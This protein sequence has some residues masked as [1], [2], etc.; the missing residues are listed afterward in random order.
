MKNRGQGPGAGGQGKERPFGPV[1]FFSARGDKPERIASEA[2]L[3]PPAPRASGNALVEFAL[4]YAGVILPLTFMLVFV[5]EMA[6]IWHSVVDFTRDGARYAATHCYEPDGSNVLAYMQAN[7]PLMIDQQQFQSNAAGIEIAYFSRNLDGSLSAFVPDACGGALC[8][9]DS[10]SVSIANYQ[11]QRFSSYF[12]L[13][14]VAI[15]PFTTTVPMES[16]GY[17]DASGVC[18]P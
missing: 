12:K 6:W 13:P 14:P 2:S 7:V 16:G 9:P 11:F 10:V 5:A 18:V 4:L 1:F 8:M 15:P 17:Q 3:L